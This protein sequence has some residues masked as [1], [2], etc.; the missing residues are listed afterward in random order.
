MGGAA[1]AI[2]VV[3]GVG[4][5]TILLEGSA[6]QDKRLVGTS[7]L[8]I[9]VPVGPGGVTMGS[10]DVSL[11]GNVRQYRRCRHSGLGRRNRKCLHPRLATSRRPGSARQPLRVTPTLP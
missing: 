11:V 4:Q 3:S 5:V 6:S 7:D 1:G 2:G 10:G 9:Y 8:S